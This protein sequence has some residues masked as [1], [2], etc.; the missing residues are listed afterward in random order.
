M[1]QSSSN[2]VQQNTPLQSKWRIARIY[3]NHCLWWLKSIAA[4]FVVLLLGSKGGTKQS[5]ASPRERLIAIANLESLGDV[6]LTLS[7]VTSVHEAD[8]AARVVVIVRPEYKALVETL[9]G[10]CEILTLSKGLWGGTFSVVKNLRK[11]NLTCAIN[12]L[13][14]RSPLS[15][16]VVLL[17]RAQTMIGFAGDGL[18]LKDPF[19][20][21]LSSFYTIIIPLEG[22]QVLGEYEKLLRTLGINRAGPL[23]PS[24]RPSSQ[25]ALWVDDLLRAWGVNQETL[26]LGIAPG[27]STPLKKWPGQKFSELLERLDG[28][29]LAGVIFGIRSER[30]EAERIRTNAHIAVFNT[31]GDLSLRQLVALLARCD[32]VVGNDTGIMHLAVAVNKPA[33]VIMAGGEPDRFFPYAGASVIRKPVVCEGCRWLCPY[34]EPHCITEIG[35]EQVWSALAKMIEKIQDEK[36]SAASIRQ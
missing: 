12:A 3:W 22:S 36:R 34:N 26:L 32:I 8:P 6:T 18:F 10:V 19:R 27:A 28:R 17:S 30:A 16:M 7:L 31:A 5:S 24:L 2:I 23:R 13:L 4:Y 33:L 1:V 15:D 29:Q 35:V 14:S 11:R 20:R 21:L 9:N 25:D